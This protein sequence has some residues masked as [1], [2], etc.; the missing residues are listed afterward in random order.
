[1]KCPTCHKETTFEGNPFRPF[2]SE[3]CRLIDLGLWAGGEFRIPSQEKPPEDTH[4]S[5]GK[6]EDDD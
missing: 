1:M 2:C 4:P 3:R 6:A 5:N